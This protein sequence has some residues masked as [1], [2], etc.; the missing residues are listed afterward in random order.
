M[1]RLYANHAVAGRGLGDADSGGRAILDILTRLFDT[2]GFPPR[3]HCGSWSAEL[4]WLHI[5]SDLAVWG[6]YVTIPCVL[7]YFV[8]RRKNLPFRK[9]FLLF[10]AFILAC[11]TTHLLEAVIFWW[12]VYRLAGVVKLLTAVVSW[13]TVFALVRVTPI[14]L[15]MRSPAEL[16]REIEERKRA[17]AELWDAEELLRMVV[18]HASNGIISIDER[19][20]IQSFNRATER[21]FRCSAADAIGQKVDVLVPELADG[22]STDLA[23]IVGSSRALEGRRRDGTHFPLE[24]RV[25]EFRLK[26][27]RHFIGIL[28]DLSQRTALEEQLRQAQKMEMTGQ[29]AGGIAHDF[30]NLLTVILGYSALL[31][32]MAHLD[33]DTKSVVAEIRK[34]GNRAAT[35]TRQLLAFSRKQVLETKLLDLNS[36]VSETEKLLARLIGEDVALTTKLSPR[37]LAVKVDA[38]Q[39]GQVIVNLALNARDAMPQGGQLTIETS[40]VELNVRD[41]ESLLNA[42][43]GSYA[44]LSVADTGVGMDA[45]T[46]AHVF[47]P[48]FTT[49]EVG[50]GSGLGLATVYGIVHQS[51]AQIVFDSE[52]RQGTRF[53]VYFPRVE[54]AVVAAERE[55]PL[56]ARARG[57]ETVLVV[58]DEEMVRNLTCRMLR[59]RGF[60]VLEA[61]NGGEALALCARHRGKIHLVLSDVVMPHMSGRQ[62]AER[63]HDVRPDLPVLFM[64]G[65]TDDAIVRHGVL[66][67]ETDFIQKPYSPDALVQRIR[68]IMERKVRQP[69]G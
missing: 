52:P 37:P 31:S 42:E 48:F 59:S 36:I 62:L 12:P 43:P 4:G 32:D 29:L 53:R 34:A 5:V 47:E 18:E 13:A 46:R 40:A 45:N 7:A 63:L 1:R 22:P 15:A 60:S 38:G 10:G 23:R 54:G 9:V 66:E 25:T 68:E 69:V 61:A 35:L 19:G 21:M 28:E 3:W 41:A 26:D 58:E 11:G 16:E 27:R 65:Y 8:L 33:D 57:S 49:K 14:A 64:S 20:T 30:N 55:P 17:Q 6:A 50:K 51:G 2:S 39:I 56:A 44:V 24:L 67:S